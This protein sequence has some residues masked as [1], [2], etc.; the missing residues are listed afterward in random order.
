MLPLVTLAAPAVA[1]IVYVPAFVI[2]PVVVADPV[3]SVVGLG[4][5]KLALPP[6]FSWNVTCC[7]GTAFPNWSATATTIVK[8]VLVSVELGGA[9]VKVIVA[10]APAVIV[11]VCVAEVTPVEAAV[12]VGV[13]AF[14][15]P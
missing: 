2:L 1:A 7:D 9:A 10:G 8:F 15:S 3:K 12:M 14:V 6:G 5:L 4:P 11:S 13:P